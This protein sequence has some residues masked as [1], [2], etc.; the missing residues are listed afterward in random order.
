MA[1]FR[2]QYEQFFGALPPY[3]PIKLKEGA[4]ERARLLLG[5]APTAAPFA[6]RQALPLEFPDIEVEPEYSPIGGFLR[7]GTAMT[8]EAL[9]GAVEYAT[10]Q[11]TPESATGL[12][13]AMKATTAGLEAT[14]GELT[15]YRQ[16]IYDS[17][18][19]EVMAAKGAE[20]LTL[21]PEK[22]IWKGGP[23]DVG[24]S[25]LYKFVES[26]PMSVLTIIPGAVAIRAGA[27][28]AGLR[29]LGA[30]EA[31][32]SVGFI[33]NETT[34][35]IQDMSDEELTRESPRFAQLLN[36]NTPEDARYQL[37]Q[38]A[39][40]L[41][42]VLGGALVGAISHTAGRYLEPVL[43][44]RAAVKTAEGVRPVGALGR[45][46]RG[47]VSEGLMQEG[48]QEVIEQLSANISASVYD[49]DRALTEGLAE[50]YVQGAVVGAPMGGIVGGMI[51]T[52]REREVPEVEGEGEPPTPPAPFGEVFTPQEPPPGG[53]TGA[54]GEMFPQ[55]EERLGEKFGIDIPKETPITDTDIDPAVAAAVAANIRRDKRMD[56]MLSGL[57]DVERQVVQPDLPLPP[58]IGQ[59]VVP[60]GYPFEPAGPGERGVRAGPTGQVQL[61]LVQR[62]RGV[63]PQ[64][65][66]LPEVITRPGERGAVL[67]EQLPVPARPV[68]TDIYREGSVLPPP[69]ERDEFYFTGEP[70]PGAPPTVPTEQQERLFDEIPPGVPDRPTAEPMADIQAQL[71]D[72]QDPESAREGVFLSADNLA[73]LQR[74]EL[75]D[76]IGGVGVHLVDFDGQGGLL[77]A[78]D[79]GVARDATELRDQGFPMEFIL[80]TLTRAGIAKPS[81]EGEA[82]VQLRDRDGNVIRETA[83]ETEAEADA[84]AEQWEET[85]KEGEDVVVRTPQAVIMRRERLIE[86]ERLAAEEPRARRAKRRARL[87]EEIEEE[88]IIEEEIPEEPEKIDVRTRLPVTEREKLKR[89]VKFAKG[90]EEAGARLAMIGSKRALLERQ[91]RVKGFF[92]PAA[93]DFPTKQM[94]EQYTDL[95]NRLVE[96]QLAK[97]ELRLGV[98][99]TYPITQKKE[100]NKEEKDLTR[101]LAK[102]RQAAKP[103]V[104]VRKVVAAARKISPR[105]TKEITERAERLVAKEPEKAI[106]PLVERDVLVGQFKPRTFAEIQKLKGNELVEAFTEAA[107]WMAG[108][109]PPKTGKRQLLKEVRD[110]YDVEEMT[111][112]EMA[113]LSPHWEDMSQ[114]VDIVKQGAGDPLAKLVQAYDSPS[115]MRKVINRASIQW[116]FVE[117][118]TKPGKAAAKKRVTIKAIV[119]E[120]ARVP[121]QDVGIEEDILLRQ[122]ELREESKEERAAREREAKTSRGKLIT[123]TNA[124][125][126]FIQRLENPRSNFGKVF[127]E[128]DPKT[129][130][131]KVDASNLRIAKAYFVALQQLALSLAQTGY[132]SKNAIRQMNTLTKRLND[133]TKLSPKSFVEQMAKAAQVEERESLRGIKDPRIKAVVT[134]KQKRAKTLEAYYK[135]L[136][137]KVKARARMENRWKK[138]AWYNNTVGPLMNRFVDSIA[139]KGWPDYRPNEMEMQGLRYAMKRWR[140]VPSYKKDFYNPMK[141]FFEGVGVKF[142]ED[143][144]VI[145]DYKE[146]PFVDTIGPYTEEYVWRPGYP[147]LETKAI[148]LLKGQK[149]QTEEAYANRFDPLPVQK[150]N[151][152][153]EK[154]L[155]YRREAADV[156][157]RRADL[158]HLELVNRVNRAIRALQ[159]VASNPKSTIKKLI[160]AELKFI[161]RMRELG[162]WEYTKSPAFGNIMM[163]TTKKY[164]RVALRLQ[165]KKMSKEDARRIMQS[166]KPFREPKGVAYPKH[167]RT[168]EERARE[169]R[170]EALREP[171]ADIEE[172][173][174][175]LELALEVI[176]PIGNAEELQASAAAIGDLLQD[177][178]RPAEIRDVLN[179]IIE[180]LPEGH[181][182]RQVAEDLIRRNI[183]PDVKVQWGR[184]NIFDPKKDATVRGRFKWT[185]TG[186]PQIYMNADY[187]EKTAQGYVA[188][189][190]EFV[191]TVLHEMYHAGTRRALQEDAK[192]GGRY[193]VKPLLDLRDYLVDLAVA[194]E[195]FQEWLSPEEGKPALPYGL[196]QVR[197]RK[198]GL[199]SGQLARF[200]FDPESPT[201]KGLQL[202]D[203]FVAEA[204]TNKKFQDELKKIKLND[205]LE[206][207]YGRLGTAWRFFANVVRAALGYKQDRELTAFDLLLFARD[208]K[209]LFGEGLF[210]GAELTT[211]LEQIILDMDGAAQPAAEQVLGRL[212][213]S[214]RSMGRVWKLAKRGIRAPLSLM[215]LRQINKTFAKYFGGENGP[216]SKYAKLFG[217]KNAR[218]SDLLSAASK[219]VRDWVALNEQYG[220]EW[221]DR[222]S[223]LATNATEAKV[224]VAENLSSKANEHLKT[225]EQKARWAE[226]RKEYNALPSEYKKLYSRLQEYYRNS[227]NDQVNLMMLNA[228]RGVLTLGAETRVMTEEEFNKKY[229]PETIK[230]F[231]T[232]EKFNEEFGQYFD[233]KNRASMLAT[234]NKMASIRQM[235]LGDYSP[236]K[237]YGDYVVYAKKQTASRDILT[238]KEA[239]EY[240]EQQQS[241]DPMVEVYLEKTDMHMGIPTPGA[242]KV[243][244]TTKD[245]RMAET[246]TQAEEERA[247]MIELYGEDAV[248]GVEKRINTQERD[249]AIR[250]NQALNSIIATLKGNPAAQ[251]AIKN[252][253]LDQLHDEAFRKHSMRR[254]N[255]KGAKRDLQ[256]RNFALYAK[257]SSYHTAQ[258]EYGGRLA[259]AMDEI[260]RFVRDKG[261]KSP[262]GS[263]RMSEIRNHLVNRDKMTTD[264]LNLEKGIKRSVEFTQFMMLT[265]PSYWMINS[266]QPYMV[267]LPV[268]AGRYGL[269]NSLASLRHAQ[270]L[271]INPLV[272]AVRDAKGG[273]EAF[274]SQLETEKAF[275]ILDDVYA[276]IRK[277]DPENADNLISMLKEVERNNLLNLSW[278]A[279]LRDISEGVH[280]GMGQKVLDASRIMTHLTE[281]NN[282]VLTSVSTYNLAVQAARENP[283]LGDP[284]AYGVAEAMRVVSE[285]Q[286]DYSAPNKPLL[287]QPGGPLGKF[288]PLVFQFMQWPQHMYALMVENFYEATKGKSPEARKEA[289]NIL[290]GLFTTHLV[291]GGILGAT[292]QPI[293]WAIGLTMAAFGDDE[294]TLTSAISGESYDR[295]VTKNA[296]NLFGSDIALLLSKGLP[297]ALGADL[298]ARMAIGTVFFLDFKGN[299]AETVAGS[300]M[301]G[302]GGATVNQVANFWRGSQRFLEGD[303]Q[304]GIEQFSPKI[305]RDVVK[306]HRF[307]NEGL[308][309]NAGDTLI[310]A[311]DVGFGAL[312]SQAMGIQ[313]SRISQFYEAERAIR[314]TERYYRERK[315]D[316][317]RDYRA[318]D[319]PA[320]YRRVLRAAKE[321]SRRNP[322]LRITMED[323]LRSRQEQRKRERR[324]QRYGANI[325]ERA[326][327]QFAE[328]G[329]PYR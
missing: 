236:L 145:V 94:E 172:A 116:R 307:W 317:L 300:L 114:I 163:G 168:E 44:G 2:E 47:A 15:A 268:L 75:R 128:T 202:V 72:L 193:L 167:R 74:D 316:I 87:E 150:F 266:T 205:F 274:R 32:L 326:A 270:K 237:R 249:A 301:L 325:S 256:L 289:R 148:A 269:G 251:E 57:E 27:S 153:R 293:K 159:K 277:R 328:Y 199:K 63:E 62:Q 77:I 327:R 247:H 3:D 35:A 287:F 179:A 136:L 235:R 272:T 187:F 208:P 298:S 48:P 102:I 88:R 245:F 282:R 221:G 59:E 203:E 192:T 273:L 76:L 180:N 146:G 135:K 197:Q 101:Q 291:A 60:A 204:F 207:N 181:F 279:E 25:I 229:T 18:G 314:D 206:Q 240:A 53:Y 154:N 267:T 51:G 177:R 8:G 134:N 50:A 209:G 260:D 320:E 255:V 124:A 112:D 195:Y 303:Y 89:A 171:I 103:K 45:I 294:D 56:D 264:P 122:T 19:D 265:S 106:T 39:Q 12:R 225:K 91:R 144:D 321:F 40:G 81:V 10:R 176:D 98:R 28:T 299:N 324:I 306:A 123:A 244:T 26:I 161:K 30:S 223:A 296:A 322:A 149:Y 290:Y 17:L 323:M 242:Y 186:T 13:E 278:I 147:A 130:Q 178:T 117:H 84:L 133:I 11:L 261:D 143:G 263:L 212:D 129:G 105:A 275:N 201:G 238:Y 55:L 80:G 78:K 231:D 110:S 284:H 96:N 155:Q 230:K 214:M 198:D 243:I 46:G 271:I 189:G 82:V 70:P 257:Q 37:I 93:L 280:P 152:T 286:F 210:A 104:K 23:L 9:L 281:V 109:Y 253:Y 305:L 250:S 175:E 73:R 156:Q 169:E 222:F 246:P 188:K 224:A 160:N 182:Y 22:T 170:I 234:I 99:P 95:F 285:S 219:V 119:P 259:S 97:E 138:N 115:K 21:D 184:R 68:P 85:A 6:R 183:N 14:R 83:V 262:L 226:L 125:A 329:E 313:P 41:A 113:K 36:T 140:A 173:E 241:E 310:E 308:V 254:K 141:D 43:T 218:Q 304:K 165:Q 86:Q 164:R 213:S 120:G 233:D 311:K 126:K 108:K 252:F 151:E 302:L 118:G 42:P 49:G 295:W 5:K 7:T 200:G 66:Q 166:L 288:S 312:F 228:L 20:F 16:R 64:D 121:V 318:A 190:E 142:D 248:G 276:H 162:V 131:A 315:S 67:H 132:S 191:H 217:Q 258:L 92:R 54:P 58:P 69:G 215:T 4:E 297:A 24:R 52:S 185:A 90:R 283:K 107:Y 194:G 139:V 71:Q 157:D 29:Y 100:L 1:S 65:I 33:A 137:S 38:E 292:L 211:P 216:L 79:E 319:T 309:N 239:R 31:G 220:K 158:K 174:R 227:L 196:T 111:D 61:P 232:V 34:D 127:A